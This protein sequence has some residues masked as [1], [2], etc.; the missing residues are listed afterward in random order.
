MPFW[1][2]FLVKRKLPYILT[3]LLRSKMDLPYFLEFTEKTWI[4]IRPQLEKMLDSDPH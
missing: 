2:F 1:P 3:I 4:R